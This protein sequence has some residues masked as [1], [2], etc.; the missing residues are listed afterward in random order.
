MRDRSLT[1]E[2]VLEPGV[3]WGAEW[4][5]LLHDSLGNLY[6]VVVSTIVI[7]GWFCM[8]ESVKGHVYA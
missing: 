3:P 2:A 6:L 8:D 5:A 4:R 7:L 1:S